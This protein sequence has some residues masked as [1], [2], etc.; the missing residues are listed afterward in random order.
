MFCFRGGVNK[1][2]ARWRVGVRSLWPLP[3]STML[4][5]TPTKV[6]REFMS[7]DPLA[8]FGSWQLVCASR[9][10]I[11]F[12]VVLWHGQVS[13]SLCTDGDEPC[14]ALGDAL[15]DVSSLISRSRSNGEW[16]L[17]SL[18]SGTARVFACVP[19]IYCWFNGIFTLRRMA[20]NQRKKEDW[21][22]FQ[23]NFSFYSLRLELLVVEMDKMDAFRIKIRRYI[24]FSDKYI[25]MEGVLFI[26]CP[27]VFL[28][29]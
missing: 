26:L 25:R 28:L 2:V 13:S 6:L 12:R 9:R 4:D 10:A 27:V 8:L 23:C 20:S 19:F 1:A 11:F 5:P 17:R 18:K 22:D 3:I 29:Y 15:T 7:S 16:L 24:H 21:Y 14:S